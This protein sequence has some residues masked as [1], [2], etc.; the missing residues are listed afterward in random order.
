VQAL[1]TVVGRSSTRERTDLASELFHAALPAVASFTSPRAWATTLLGLDEY[2]HAFGGDRQVED[3]RA[4]LTDRLLDIYQRAGSPDWPWFE[5]RV[6]YANAQLPHALIASGTRMARPDLVSAGLTAL[7]WLV[8]IQRSPAGHFLP[9][10][11]NGFK[12]RGAD[13]ARFDQ[14]PIEASTTV[15]ACLEAARVTGDAVWAG[16]ARLAFDWF[17]GQNHLRQWLYDPASG[18]C[19]DGLHDERVNEN[20]GAESTLAFLSAL[21]DIRAARRADAPLEVRA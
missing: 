7:T 11:T 17:L 3:L 19:R 18:G 10:G 15:A 8:A 9:I 2:L 4:R 13:A 16:E 6:T 20:Q 5:D 14:Q 12:V 1:G 21:L